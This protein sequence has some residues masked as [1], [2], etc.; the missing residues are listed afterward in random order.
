MKKFSLAVVLLFY[1]QLI[2]SQ[3]LYVGSGS[4][5]TLPTD[6]SIVFNGLVLSPTTTYTVASNTTITRL[7]TAANTGNVAILRQYTFSQALTN[8]TGTLLFHYEDS[9]L[10]G[11]IETE[12]DL[13]LYG[14]DTMWH[15]FA[16]SVDANQNTLTYNFTTGVNFSIITADISEALSVDKPFGL[17]HLTVYPNPTYNVVHI[18]YPN[19]IRTTLHNMLGQ[20][21]QKGTSHHIDLSLYEGAT[22]FLTIEDVTNQNQ[23]T[24]KIIKR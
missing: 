9:E 10:N 2:L 18:K 7:S 20:V 22:Y 1:T 8:Y 19:A 24:I 17:E 5:V 15:A 14:S 4:Y 13:Q 23:K 12:L 11:A 21:L 6:S 16:A 3:D